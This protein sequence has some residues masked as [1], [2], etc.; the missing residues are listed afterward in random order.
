MRVLDQREGHKTP[1]GD[2]CQHSKIINN[3][4]NNLGI[5]LPH[6]A[7]TILLRIFYKNGDDLSYVTKC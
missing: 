4:N 3:S 5:N 2:G 7:K 1:T 6:K